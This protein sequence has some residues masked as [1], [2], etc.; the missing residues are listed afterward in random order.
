M[1]SKMK[2][3]IYSV[4][5]AASIGLLVSCDQGDEYR[6]A[7]P[8]L[9]LTASTRIFAL[10][11]D[12][13]SRTVVIDTNCGDWKV[14]TDAAGWLSTKKEDNL[15]TVTALESF[16]SKEQ[17]AVVTVAGTDDPSLKCEI[18]VMQYGT[19]ATNLSAD[20]T[21]NCYMARTGEACVFEAVIKGNGGGDGMS[22]YIDKHG[23]SLDDGVA[24]ELLWEATFDA[25]KTRSREV[26]DGAPVY[27]N[28]RIWFTTGRE[29]GN[30][31][32]A[33]RDFSGEI[34]W[35]WHIWVTDQEVTLK[36]ANGYEW[37]DRNLG[38]LNNTP[39]D[40]N[41]RGLFYQWGRKDP[42]L[43]S[44]A[45]YMEENVPEANVENY[46]VG[47]GTAEWA[48]TGVRQL[49]LTEAPG[50]IE[51]AVQHPTQFLKT[52]YQYSGSSWYV[53]P[54]NDDLKQ[55]DL[56]GANKSK[57][58]YKTIFDPCPVGYMVPPD[59]A[60]ATAAGDMSTGVN[61]D[62]Q[63]GPFERQGRT[64]TG[65]T[66]DFFPSAGILT[67]NTPLTNCGQ[68]GIYWTASAD[69]SN[70]YGYEVYVMPE[71]VRYRY[72]A[73]AYGNSVRCVKEK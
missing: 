68:I 2:K 24:A 51:N 20:G 15:L 49:L 9:Y 47:D 41:N 32:I 22:K 54:T 46:Q 48:Y 65:G 29:Q 64:W 18:R 1:E 39:G 12:G 13:G 21:A 38:A 16:S 5:L 60:F 23:L 73:T 19:G 28:G 17:T 35:S 25:D 27:Q 52:Y 66:G 8:A 3:L 11:A 33:L 50:N 57:A 4:L 7:E 59:G 55:A 69:A 71:W 56:W 43:P 44:S 72:G 53:T 45:P 31:V 26:I 37:M 62:V 30:A 10:P 58:G 70:G 40:L 34:V 14:S 63:W 67:I 61:M 36:A 42:F 6:A